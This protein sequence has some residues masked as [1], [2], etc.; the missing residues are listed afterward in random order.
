MPPLGTMLKKAEQACVAAALR[1]AA[2]SV[3]DLDL[4]AGLITRKLVSNGG[5]AV[6]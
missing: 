4:Y 1:Q 6:M 3:S 2:A 5:G